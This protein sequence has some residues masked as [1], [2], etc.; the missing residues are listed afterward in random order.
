MKKAHDQDQASFSRLPIILLWSLLWVVLANAASEVFRVYCWQP[1]T[2]PDETAKL[3]S[4]WGEFKG[5]DVLLV[6]SSLV[7]LGFASPTIQAEA[8]KSLGRPVCVLNLGQRG[9]S[10]ESAASYLRAILHRWSPRV[11]LWGTS[12]QECMSHQGGHFLSTYASPLDVVATGFRFYA[13]AS[14]RDFERSISALMRAP[15]LILE[16]GAFSTS[17]VAGKVFLRK[18]TRFQREL[19]WIR[20]YGG[21]APRS[22]RAGG[23]RAGWEGMVHWQAIGSLTDLSREYGVHLVVLLMPIDEEAVKREAKIRGDF[24]PSLAEYCEAKQIPFVDLAK[25]PFRPSPTD[26]MVDGRHIVAKG[27]QKLSRLIASRVLVPLLKQ[28]RAE[29][30]Q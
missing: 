3:S 27:A 29:H 26:Y 24:A 19:A 22:G 10:A 7:E 28:P 8:E 1:F 15:A 18:P 23:S 20:K 12:P 4:A 9:L 2:H 17:E 13:T 6:G 14:W 5:C 16:F 30:E 21:W 11:I 25:E